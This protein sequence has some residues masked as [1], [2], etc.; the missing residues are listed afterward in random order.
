MT[1]PQEGSIINTATS[2]S[3]TNFDGKRNRESGTQGDNL[4]H[5]DSE[6]RK[7]TGGSVAPRNNE[8]IDDQAIDFHNLVVGGD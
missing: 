5:F 4:T 1:S 3:V 2:S 8:E 7:R 6:I